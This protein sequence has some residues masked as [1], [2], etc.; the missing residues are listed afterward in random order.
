VT[1]AENAADIDLAW[2]SGLRYDMGK[3]ASCRNP[4]E[5]IR[6]RLL[7]EA[8]LLGG[9]RAT[10]T[11][12]SWTACA[13]RWSSLDYFGSIDIQPNPDKAEDYLVPVDVKLTLAKRSIYTAGLSYGT[14]SGAGI[15]CGMERRYVNKRGHKAAGAAGLRAEAQDADPAVPHP[16]LQVAGRLVHRQLQASDEQTDYID[17]APAE[18]VASRSGEINEHWTAVASIHALRERW[19]YVDQIRLPACPTAY[20]TPPS[21]IPRCARTTPTCRRP[22]VSAPTAAGAT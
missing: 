1:R 6:S 4:K 2:D 12:A 18:F 21:P 8:D 7:E 9:R 11:R 17:S 13:N 5:I 3:S 16:G 15:A 22:A 10:S 14:E 20:N 19:R